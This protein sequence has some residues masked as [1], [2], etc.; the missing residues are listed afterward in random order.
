[1]VKSYPQFSQN[2]EPDGD[3]SPQLGQVTGPPLEP[4][5]EASAEAV[6]AGSA[7]GALGSTDGRPAGIGVPHTSQ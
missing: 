2:R 6:A 3:R 7:A 4:S 5:V 1:V